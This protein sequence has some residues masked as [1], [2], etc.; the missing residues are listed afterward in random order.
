MPT[1]GR[2]VIEGEAQEIYSFLRVV[3]FYIYTERASIVLGVG[4]YCNVHVYARRE[5]D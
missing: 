5:L 4:S 3:F 2:D 1:P